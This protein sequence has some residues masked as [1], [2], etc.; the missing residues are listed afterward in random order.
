MKVMFHNCVSCSLAVRWRVQIFRNYSRGNEAPDTI[1]KEKL[2][3]T[4]VDPASER[5]HQRQHR[6]QG[7]RF[8]RSSC[9]D[10]ASEIGDSPQWSDGDHFE[11]TLPS[12]AFEDS[13]LR[14]K[15]A[16]LRLSLEKDCKYLTLTL[17]FSLRLK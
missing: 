16:K 4:T 11:P 15:P 2:S 1:S 6:Q 5:L 14:R 12:M 10:F 7:Q 8:V 9:T 3:S 17:L 13:A